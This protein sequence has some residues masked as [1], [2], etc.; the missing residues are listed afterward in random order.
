[1]WD[2]SRWAAGWTP[3]ERLRQVMADNPDLNVIS[4]DGDI[5]PAREALARAE[6]EIQAAQDIAPL[7]EIAVAC[8]LR[9]A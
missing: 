2:R 4:P 1:M 9:V 5:L 6:R 7:H 3:S 8:A